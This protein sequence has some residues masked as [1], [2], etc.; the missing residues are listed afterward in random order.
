MSAAVKMCCSPS[1]SASSSVRH[2]P[3]RSSSLRWMSHAP[4]HQHTEE[5]REHSPQR[6]ARG[7]PPAESDSFASALTT[8]SP[9]RSSGEGA[10]SKLSPPPLLLQQAELLGADGVAAVTVIARSAA[11]ASLFQPASGFAAQPAAAHA[12][13]L[14]PMPAQQLGMSAQHPRLVHVAAG[15]QRP[16]AAGPLPSPRASLRPRPQ[17]RRFK[18]PHA[19]LLPGEGLAEDPSDALWRQ[20]PAGRAGQL[21]PLLGLLAAAEAGRAVQLHPHVQMLLASQSART[22][23]LGACR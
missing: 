6:S 17:T 15:E 12:P 16:A 2:G 20:P 1:P 21:P 7:A 13:L 4:H 10:T 8:A 19:L 14:L 18:R 23:R 11:T 9:G 5:P 22:S 3:R